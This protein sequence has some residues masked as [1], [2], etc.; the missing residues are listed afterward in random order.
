M[1]P[2]AMSWSFCLVTLFFQALPTELQEAVQF[3]RCIFHDIS[4]L[5][6]SLLHKQSLQSLREHA[7]VTYKTLTDESRRIRRIMSTM[8]SDRGTS[9]NNSFVQSHYSGSSAEQTIVA[10]S[11]PA[12]KANERPLVKKKTERVIHVTLLMVTLVVGLMA[13]LVV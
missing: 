10:H 11:N 2:N 13:S 12:A 6:T 7:V 3:G 4:K 1:S 5:T 9:N 8:N